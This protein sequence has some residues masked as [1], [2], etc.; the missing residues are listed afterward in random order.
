MRKILALILACF[1]LYWG[2]T[3]FYNAGENYTDEYSIAS[4]LR[5]NLLNDIGEITIKNGEN[6]DI[7]KTFNILESIYPYSFSADIKQYNSGKVIISIN[8]PDKETQDKGYKIAQEIALSLVDESMS[9]YRKLEK[10]HNY[11][12]LNTVYDVDT[13]EN[14]DA[15]DGSSFWAYG[16]AVDGL[17]VCSGYSRAMMIMADAVGIDMIYVASEEMNH[18]WNALMLEEKIYYIDA[19]YDD[20]VPD[21]KGKASLKYFMV[22]EETLA[23]D[24]SWDA[25]F[26][27]EIL[28]KLG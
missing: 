2:Y 11:I 19:T 22:D 18:G 28:Y 3:H 15:T 20:P 7:D 13:F 25:E 9:D 16:S 17:A 5:A 1:L 21:R 24:H 12:V 27:K 14:N 10:I 23:K 8:I 26:Y 4:E 6:F